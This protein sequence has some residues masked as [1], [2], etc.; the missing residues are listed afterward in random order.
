MQTWL[1][2]DQLNRINNTIRYVGDYGLRW[3]YNQPESQWRRFH[4]RSGILFQNR[5]LYNFQAG[6]MLIY[7]LT[8]PSEV[9]EFRPWQAFQLNWPN[10]SRVR[11]QHLFRTEQRS[12]WNLSEDQSN[13]VFK[14][15]YQIGTRIPLFSKT[16]QPGTYFLDL[17]SEW[18][19]DLSSRNNELTNDRIRISAGVGYRINLSLDAKAFYVFQGNQDQDGASL[20][21]EHIIRLSLI[22]RFGME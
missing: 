7:T 22:Q 21:R 20:S 14:I 13:F 8:K 5:T 16:I 10:I 17:R 9:F 18:F 1:D 3:E 2:Y 11:I 4:I 15:R 19:F 6:L 12:S